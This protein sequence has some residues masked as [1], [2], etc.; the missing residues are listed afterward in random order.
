M[1]WRIQMLAIACAVTA[2]GCYTAARDVQRAGSF[3][4]AISAQPGGIVVQRCGIRL[5]EDTKHECVT[6]IVGAVFLRPFGGSSSTATYIEDGDCTTSII[7][8]R[9]TP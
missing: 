4:K 7:P 6:S 3:V 2:A 8:T 9:A 1:V 5:V